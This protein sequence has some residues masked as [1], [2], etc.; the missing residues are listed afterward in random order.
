MKGKHG[1]DDTEF[2]VRRPIDSDC[3]DYA[4]YDVL[5]LRSLHTY[6]QSEILKRPHI[7]T[8]SK[9]Y[10][11][12]FPDHRRPKNSFYIDHGVLPQEILER[13]EIQKAA[14]DGLGTRTC[15]GCRR[16]LHQDSFQYSFEMVWK[17]YLCHTCFE[18][19]R[20]RERRRR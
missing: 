16:D 5:Q 9:R 19:K 11:E 7:T 3:L 1:R 18:V 10:A 8:E 15:A 4:A 17:E 14:N 13:S 20:F 2:W 6:Y 12:M